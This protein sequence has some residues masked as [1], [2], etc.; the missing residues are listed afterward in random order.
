MSS[1]QYQVA[2]EQVAIAPVAVPFATEFVT[3]TKQEYIE[4]L[5]KGNLYQSL[6]ER[7]TKRFQYNEDRYKRLL[8]SMKGVQSKVLDVVRPP[9][10]ANIELSVSSNRPIGGWRVAFANSA[11]PV[12]SWE[13][14]KLL[15]TS[16]ASG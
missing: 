12:H 13:A 16:D 9:M 10:M 5:L 7:A 8:R 15:V 14:T 2:N 6:H 1:D 3:I 4:L 11:W